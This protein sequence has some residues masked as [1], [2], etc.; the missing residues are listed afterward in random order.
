MSLSKSLLIGLAAF[1]SLYTTAVA[2]TSPT[3]ITLSGIEKRATMTQVP[4]LWLDFEKANYLHSTLK[5]TPQKVYVVYKAFSKDYQQADVYIGY[6][7]RD[8]TR[9]KHSKSIKINQFNQVLAQGK[10][11]TK[12]LSDAWKTFDYR[13][14]VEAVLEIHTLASLGRK[15]QVE[16]L[17]QYK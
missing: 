3:K 2:A 14:Q 1:W 16:L 12:Q 4:E 17:V 5:N 10:H 9:Y 13:K 6:D 8:L 7:V 11:T 15:E